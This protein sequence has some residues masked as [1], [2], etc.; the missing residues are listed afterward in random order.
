M[1][2]SKAA[3]R[4]IYRFRNL[5]RIQKILE[6][7]LQN[8]PVFQMTQYFVIKVDFCFFK[9][10]M[11]SHNFIVKKLNQFQ[12]KRMTRVDQSHFS[13]KRPAYYHCTRCCKEAT[14]SC[15]RHKQQIEL[16]LGSEIEK[17]STRKQYQCNQCTKIGYSSESRIVCW[18]CSS[19]SI[20]LF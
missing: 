9:Y 2:A 14:P 12:T 20:K 4:S 15:L 11:Y 19:T 17:L 10:L 3:Y 16:F 5:L 18:F 6:K 13:N 8:L 1:L 7:K